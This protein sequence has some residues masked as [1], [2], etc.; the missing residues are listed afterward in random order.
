MTEIVYKA[1]PT[2]ARFH[3]SDAAMRAIVGPVGSGKSTACVMEIMMRAIKQ[4]PDD[5]RMRRTRFAVIRNTYGQLR[6]TTRKTFEEWI[7]PSSGKWHEQSFTFTMLF[8]LD[9]GTKVHSEVLFRA[10]DTNDDIRKLLSLELTGC[11]LNEAREVPWHVVEMLTTRINRYPPKSRGGATW[12]GIWMD[13]N[14]WHTKHWGY[15]LFSQK[16]PEGFTLFEQPGGRDPNAENTEHL[17]HDYYDRIVAASDEETVASYVDARYPVFDRGAIFGDLIARLESNGRIFDFE[18]PRDGVFTSWDLGFTD[19]TAIWFWRVNSDR[20]ADLVDHYEAHGQPLSHYFDVLDTKGYVYAKHWLPHDAKQ[21]TLQSGV[22]IFEQFA[23]R[24]GYGALGM[25]P[26][27]SLLD[28]I[29]AARWLLEQKIRVHSRCEPAVDKLRE[30]RYEYDDDTKTYSRR[31]LHNFASHTAD[32]FR[33]LALVVKVSDLITWQDEP[34]PRPAMAESAPLTF[35]ALLEDR[36]RRRHKDYW[37][38]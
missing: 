37:R 34:K 8:P 16:K 26:S 22:S 11:Y 33:Y 36:I 30:Y 23:E 38:I 10:L 9:D 4:N 1:S 28:G 17:A 32:A 7:P 31:P 13:T 3:T 24:Y 6:D 35:D 15:R 19:S 21:K 25:S 12:A 27:L 14:P 29:Q 18:H 20:R 5:A 2:L